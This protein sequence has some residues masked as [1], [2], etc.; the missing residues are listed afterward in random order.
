MGAVDAGCR[1]LDMLPV[2]LPAALV[3]QKSLAAFSFHFPTCPV[4]IHRGPRP[5]RTGQA[6]G[7]SGHTAP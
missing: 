6:G 4:N 3:P 7:T 2:Q 5:Q 1:A